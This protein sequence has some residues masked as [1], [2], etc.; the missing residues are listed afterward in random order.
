VTFGAPLPEMA[1]MK[2][3]CSL[4]PLMVANDCH[5]GI[6]VPF[7]TAVRICPFSEQYVIKI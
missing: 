6:E 4:L 3:S 7:Q 2:H 5:D 1:A